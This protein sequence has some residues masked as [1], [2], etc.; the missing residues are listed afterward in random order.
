MEMHFLRNSGDKIRVML[1]IGNVIGSD[2]GSLR[3]FSLKA[4]SY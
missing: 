1:Y 3:D 2:A 4:E